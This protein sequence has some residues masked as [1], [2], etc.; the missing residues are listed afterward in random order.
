ML[1]VVCVVS[2]FG[3]IDNN[4]QRLYGFCIVWQF[5]GLQGFVSLR[6]AFVFLYLLFVYVFIWFCRRRDFWRAVH[7]Q[8]QS[9]CMRFGRFSI[10]LLEHV[11]IRLER[12]NGSSLS[13][14]PEPHSQKQTLGGACPSA[15]KSG[16]GRR[17]QGVQLESS[18][19]G[20]GWKAFQWAALLRQA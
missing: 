5:H 15:R 6:F 11:T 16:G 18:L 12:T 7:F 13:T 17:R 20:L 1:C 3:G 9:F 19:S 10:M 2:L 8:E 4:C 14:F